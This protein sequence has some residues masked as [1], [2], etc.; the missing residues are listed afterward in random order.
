MVKQTV[1]Q[2]LIEEQK[3]TIATLSDTLVKRDASIAEL[4]KKLKSSEHTSDTWYKE[5][6]RLTEEIEQIHVFL[7]SLPNPVSRT[8]EAKNSWG[9]SQEKERT[10]ITRIC[11]WIATLI[12]QS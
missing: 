3:A 12:K 8:F 2:K 11:A 6:N 4:E 9:G 7:D 5:R 1:S 10:A